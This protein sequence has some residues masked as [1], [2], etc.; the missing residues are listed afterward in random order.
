MKAA[1]LDRYAKAGRLVVREV[2]VPEPAANEVLVK[3]RAAAVNP[4]ELL[5]VAGSVRLI[6][7][8]RLPQTLG[9]ECSGVVER[10]GSKVGKFRPGDAVYTR[11]PLER[12]GAFAEYVA[13]EEAALAK[14]PA[15]YAFDVAAAVPLTGLTAWQGLVEVLEAHPGQTLLIPGGSGS[16]GQMAVPIARA[17][18]L[19]VLVTGND[20]ARERFLAMGV[21]R[22]MDYRREN[23]W[24][25]LSG[26]DLVI[27]TL[28]VGE[29][30]HELSVLKPGG[31][32]LSLRTAPNGEFARRSGFPW[33]K[34][35][36]FSLAGM[37]YD[38]ARSTGLCSCMPT[39]H[40]S[41]GLRRSSNAIISLRPLTRTVS[42]WIGSTTPCGL[43]PMVRSGERSLFTSKIRIPVK[44]HEICFSPTGGTRRVAE[45]LSQALANEIVPVDLTARDVDFRSVKLA[46][47]DVALIAV[48]SYS[49]RVP[50]VA[51]TRLEMLCGNGARTILVCVY[52]NRAYEDTLAELRDTATRAGFRV[53]AAV[54]AVAEHSIV[55][56]YGAGRPDAA[57]EAV[58]R[59]FAV[60]IRRKIDDADDSEPK[61]PGH[62][63]YRKAA[64]TG[65]IPKATRS[66]VQC[67]VCAAKCPVGAIDPADPTRVDKKV[68]ISCMRCVAVCP[69]KAR[70]VNGLLLA[71]VGRLL[72]KACS[73]RKSCEVYL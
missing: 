1:Q 50:A 63:P 28:G 33:Y 9:N 60:R 26:I 27:D 20:R 13:V 15:G 30:E 59:N 46:D 48:P 3:V 18:G 44:I 66:C 19:R 16:F 8:Y 24:E 39:E 56:Q 45:I 53:V 40:S 23:Y 37:K 55:R 47:G 71:L 6:Q 62:R 31:R 69:H 34:R 43:W 49:G 70:R 51:A 38:R 10:V 42:R 67:G 25:K 35:V 72:K 58:L 29:F 61:I 54:A 64:G 5:L 32:L 2:P 57:D 12:I 14:M 4:L 11:L 36:L 73:E 41:T 7:D 17:L 52:G 22:Y 65:L 68:C 21:E